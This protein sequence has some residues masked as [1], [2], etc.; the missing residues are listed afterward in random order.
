MLSKLKRG[1]CNDF[2]K[3]IKALNP[4]KES[5]SL[6][7]GGTS[8]ESNSTNLWK[9]HFSATANFVGST[10]NRDQVMN[11]LRTVQGHS[12]VINVHELR[13]IVKGLK[14]NK[15]VGND[16]IPPEVYKFAS[17]RLLT[18]MSILISGCM[19]TGELPNSLMHVVIILLLKC[20][21]KDPADV[22]NYRP[23]AIATA[24]SKVLEQV[25]LS[26]LTR[27]LWTADSQFSFKEAHGTSDMFIKK[28]IL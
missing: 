6:T 28:N 25:L 9:D 23:I 18:M 17:Q 11:A 14:N 12:D 8:G 4:K 22:D 24:F 2:W 15:A 27:Y 3:E 26:R 16:G 10:D 21:L 5:L 19:P 13:Q 7:V 20:K 1:E